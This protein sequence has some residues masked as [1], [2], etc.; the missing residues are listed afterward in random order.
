MSFPNLI[1]LEVGVSKT[2]GKIG[3]LLVGSDSALTFMVEIIM[4]RAVLFKYTVTGLAKVPVWVPEAGVPI[5]LPLSNVANHAA[6]FAEADIDI[7]LINK[8][9]LP[10]KVLL[11]LLVKTGSFNTV[12]TVPFGLL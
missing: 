10:V 11:F 2:V 4:G 8:L 7:P 9:H 6:K 3:L 12:S 5:I 1:S